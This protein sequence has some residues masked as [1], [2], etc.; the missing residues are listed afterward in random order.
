MFVPKELQY[1][2]KYYNRPIKI[3]T[4][5]SD[6]YFL[7]RLVTYY[8]GDEID[9][10]LGRDYRDENKLIL[11]RREVIS[12][13]GK[14]SFVEYNDRDIMDFNVIRQFVFDRR[15]DLMILSTY[16]TFEVN[17]FLDSMNAPR[18]LTN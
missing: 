18:I 4:R 2:I 13:G 12:T 3:F 8:K 7:D 9:T 17:D 10:G 15:K 1:L 11:Y 14:F 16:K 6:Y 5:L